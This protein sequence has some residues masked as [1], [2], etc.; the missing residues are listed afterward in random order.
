MIT[1]LPWKVCFIFLLVFTLLGNV[2]ASDGKVV[3]STGVAAMAN[4]TP[5]EAQ[6]LALKR[7]RQ[8]AI[9]EVCGVSVQ[10]ETLIHNNMLAADFIHSVSYGRIIDEEIL[11]WDAD[12]TRESKRRPPSVAYRV[13][14][15]ARVKPEKG[16]PDPYYQVS[17]G[18]NKK[19]YRSGD[20]MI[21]RVKATKP[22]YISVLNFAAD[23]SVILLY[24]NRLRKSNY[25]KALKQY[26]IPSE[27]DRNDVLKLQVSTLPGHRKDTEFIKVIATR[28][29]IHLLDGLLTQGRY[30]VMDTV[31][32]AAV[33]IARLISA[34]PLKDRAEHTVFYE[35]VSSE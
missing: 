9:E 23:G 30:G 16:K 28:Q 32:L 11:S 14:I 10:A 6:A 34:I 13:K 19:V 3:T 24:P 17:V 31:N 20:E 2:L 33:E 15:R 27:T 5:E 12:V 18:L 29:P 22:S 25:I 8:N 35:I 1:Q 7:A 4:L 26:Q 21:I